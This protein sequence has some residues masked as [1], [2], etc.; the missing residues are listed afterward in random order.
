M[1]PSLRLSALNA[2]PISTRRIALAA[3]KGSL[4]NLERLHNIMT[5]ATS[6]VLMLPV[7]YAALDI[8]RIPNPELLD[9]PDLISVRTRSELA[10]AALAWAILHAM[11]IPDGLDVLT[12]TTL[13]LDIVV[14]PDRFHDNDD[15]SD[16]ITATSGFYPAVARAW[17][18]LLDEEDMD[19]KDAGLTAVLNLIAAPKEK[20]REPG[21]LSELAEGV[22]GSYA[23]LASLILR[24]VSDTLGTGAGGLSG[25][26]VFALFGGFMFIS[27]VAEE[28]AQNND[29]Y[30][31][32]RRL[33][34]ELVQNDLIKHL[35]RTQSAVLSEAPD[36]V[37]GVETINK[38]FVIL[39]HLMDQRILRLIIPNA[40]DQGLLQTIVL[41]ARRSSLS[42]TQHHLEFF[43][44]ELLPSST[45]YCDV[46]PPMEEAIA[47]VKTL[48][49]TD[50]FIKSEIFADWTHF[51]SIAQER[52]ALLESFD[53]R[54]LVAQKA[55]DEL[56]CSI[57]LEKTRFQRCSA[58]QT[59]YY[60]S[61]VC[62]VAD[63]KK[64]GHR[65]T[66]SLYRSLGLT[67]NIRY[68]PRERSF[69]RAALHQEYL[70][71]R[72]QICRDA[73]IC[74]Q[75]YPDAGYFVGFDFVDSPVS[76]TVHSLAAQSWE[77]HDI[78]RRCGPEWAAYVARAVRSE[79]TMT[80]HTMRVREGILAKHWVV[81]LRAKTSELQETLK[82]IAGE[83]ASGET[84]VEDLDEEV[85]GLLE[86]LD[87]DPDEEEI[88]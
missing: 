42:E 79:G 45:V 30:N 39:R 74:L 16:R 8:A 43:L 27:D 75:A 19:L 15:I 63:W 31:P 47:G 66:C 52:F 17:K 11:E 22:G 62:Q 6:T 60:C 81:P 69:M 18:L 2:L 9:T 28:A 25:N 72:Q 88:H 57:I 67:E 3:A 40:L 46:I 49:S 55:C 13:L 71:R 21:M 7:V 38:S 24:H 77:T 32:A 12:E 1:H 80:I 14:F 41:C 20:P 48:V 26:D 10:T 56:D 23:R 34:R 4:H 50:A 82:S 54:D 36:G 37:S 44:R 73:V 83:L 53:S 78:L 51:L 61:R 58:C 33:L 85:A 68:L 5:E 76:A 87:D 70:K 86:R 29:E 64:G 59:F 84:A 35:V 65:E